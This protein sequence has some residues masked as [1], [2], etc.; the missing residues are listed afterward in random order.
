VEVDTKNRLIG[1]A[2][3]CMLIPA[4]LL[5]QPAKKTI[6]GVW[7]VKMAPA[8]QSDRPFL[9]LVMYG[10]DGSFTT[11]GGYKALPPVSAVQEV[12]TEASPGYGRWAA[13]GDRELRLTFYAIVWKQGLGNGY[14]RVQET[15]V[16][17]ETGD[18]YTGHA[19]VDFLDA[20]WNVVFSTSSDVKGTRLETPAA[21]MA[22]Q[23]EQ[24]QLVGVWEVKVSR[25]GQSQS[26][27]SG[28]A[29]YGDDGSVTTGGRYKALP[30]DSAVQD[31]ANELGPG[32]GGWAATSDREFRLTF[33]SVMWKAGL[34]TGYLRVH[35]TLVLS[36]SGDAYTGHAQVDFLDASGKVVFNTSPEVK[37]TRLETPAMSIAPPVQEKQLTGVWAKKITSFGTE[38]TLLN[39]DTYTADGSFTGSRDKTIDPYGRTAGLRAGRWVAT[40]TREFQLTFYGMRWN[41]EGVVDRFQRVQATMTLSESGDGFT[42]HSQWDILDLNWTV[43][44]RGASDVTGTRLE[45]PDQ[46]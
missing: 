33:Y 4:M 24:K 1:L 31:V 46:N 38:R 44:F 27:E 32:Y 26:P 34:V 17:S 42:E 43:V 20:N 29:M 39:I 18:E 35:D 23:A 19:Q 9:S 13:T 5:A 3:Q 45:T 15:L 12:G 10:S 8:G 14:Q 28:L 25:V 2:V 22:P 6:V 7:E 11:C 30:P 41:K 36:E 16:L 37:G 21:L 40:G